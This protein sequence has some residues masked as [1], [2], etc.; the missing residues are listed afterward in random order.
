MTVEIE[1][2]SER[3]QSVRAGIAF[4][5]QGA[6]VGTR[7]GNGSGNARREDGSV[8]ACPS[9]SIPTDPEARGAAKA[10]STAGSHH[11]Q[12]ARFEAM[13]DGEESSKLPIEVR[14]P[15]DGKDSVC[16]RV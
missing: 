9:H 16:G 2:R 3:A 1:S 15:S 14:S 5:R 8:N 7:D 11:V 4:A 6:E 12:C 10:F 13:C